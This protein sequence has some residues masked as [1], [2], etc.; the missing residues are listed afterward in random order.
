MNA[1]LT[2]VCGGSRSKCVIREV[3]LC[4]EINSMS[5]N[6]STGSKR[7]RRS[8][9]PV[10]NEINKDDSTSE[11]D[12]EISF[13]QR[14]SGIMPK[15]VYLPEQLSHKQKQNG[16]PKVTEEEPM[17]IADITLGFE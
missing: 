13:K 9:A 14:P 4:S 1:T 7:G 12:P 5:R 6:H 8:I 3:N 17:D 10:R 11:D 2:K 16:K 15:A